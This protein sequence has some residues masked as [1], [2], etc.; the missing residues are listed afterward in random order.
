[1][2]RDQQ[3]HYVIYPD[4]SCLN[5][6]RSSGRESG[7][8]ATNKAGWGFVVTNNVP[9]V[10]FKN[11]EQLKEVDYGYGRI[12][13]EQEDH[14]YV[15]CEK[16][17]NNTA[18]ITAII[19]S[20]LWVYKH[21]EMTNFPIIIRP[22]S[23]YA[24]NQIQGRNATKKNIQLVINARKLLAAINSNRDH[25]VGPIVFKHVKA[26]SGEKWN[27]KADELAVR[28]AN[29][30]GLGS[31]NSSAVTTRNDKLIEGGSD[32]FRTIMARSVNGD[33]TNVQSSG[34]RFSP[35]QQYNS[36]L[37]FTPNSVGESEEN[38][39]VDEESDAQS[40]V[41][42]CNLLMLFMSISEHVF[43]A[44]VCDKSLKLREAEIIN[45]ILAN[46][47]RE[48]M[49]P[50]H[51]IELF[52]APKAF[53]C[54]PS[55]PGQNISSRKR[56]K[57]MI[58]FRIKCMEKWEKGGQHRDALVRTVLRTAQQKMDSHNNNNS[59]NTYSSTEEANIR[60]CERLA[61]EDSQLL[62]AV[63][64]LSS[65]GIAAAGP[66]TTAQL[67]EKHPQDVELPHRPVSNVTRETIEI[68][69]N[70]VLLA[71]KSFK[72][73]AAP[74]RSGMRAQHFSTFVAC[75]PD[76]LKNLTAVI[77]LLLKGLAPDEL[78]PFITGGSLIPLL[79]KDSSIRPIAI[80]ETLTRI[81]SKI[82]LMKTIHKFKDLTSKAQC[83]IGV[84]NGTEAILHMLNNYLYSEE[85]DE[86]SV[87][88]FVDFKNA[89]NTIR[90][91]PIVD[92]IDRDIPEISCWTQFCLCC[93]S[94]LFVPGGDT[95]RSCTGLQQG[96]PLSGPQWS[97]GAQPL[98]E[99]IATIISDT[100]P[101]RN[102]TAAA[103]MD[104]W[105]LL[106]PDSE[107]AAKILK[108][109]DIKGPPLG[110]YRSATK[111]VAWSLSK[112][113]DPAANDRL[114]QELSNSIV[115]S[116]KKGV[117]LLGGAMS[118]DAQ[119]CNE[120]ALK[121]V[122]IATELIHKVL[123]L[124]DP[125]ICLRLLRQCIGTVKLVYCIRT[126][127]TDAL[128][129]A[130][131]IFAEVLRDALRKIVV[132]NGPHLGDFHI[133]LASLPIK[134]SGLG[135]HMPADLASSAALASHLDTIN[136]QLHLCPSL[137]N[138]DI[139][140]NKTTKL[141]RSF[142]DNIDPS[143]MPNNTNTFFQQLSSL[144]NTQ[145]PLTRLQ[146]QSK[147]AI[148]LKHPFL[149]GQSDPLIKKLHRTILDSTGFQPT[150]EQANSTLPV[151]RKFDSIANHWLFAIPCAAFQ[152]TM[153][154]SEYRAALAL[155]ML[156][157]ILPASRQ[158][159][160]CKK[161]MMDK[162]G[163]HALSCGGISNK[164]TKRHETLNDAVFD[165]LRISQF[166]PIKNA[167]V[168]CLGKS[169]RDE[170]LFR[171]ADCL[172]DGDNGL[173]CLDTTVVSPL[174]LARCNMRL[175]DVVLDAALA[176]VNKHLRP[177]EAAHYGFIPFA[178]D[179]CGLIDWAA[180]TL[181]KRIGCKY[182]DNT[183]KSYSEGVSIVRQRLSFALQAGIA[184][185]LARVVLQR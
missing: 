166:N 128:T 4:G 30:N 157:P 122:T 3:Q 180:A 123:R 76:F 178:A 156:I 91:Q 79:K 150:R 100:N 160:S 158:C 93:A 41:W 162:Y 13:T 183:H 163:Y 90:R 145:H 132:N 86:G 176:K 75:H 177:C 143:V 67:L 55:E 170:H 69:Q 136:L 1:M 104:D 88:L 85:F 34:G 70:D 117:E 167:D 147:R 44:K 29:S 72:K 47:V 65:C 83:G 106:V 92:R 33:N 111:S 84:R 140:N 141:Q 43:T 31:A 35:S 168:Q 9:G 15:G 11:T 66:E 40:L 58:S 74:G 63:Q 129:E 125:H 172:F 6:Q 27:E 108:T 94:Y 173:T 171:P 39:S 56:R 57:N 134:M 59:C 169:S 14:E 119:F 45:K 126:L 127:P 81:V 98:L 179:T 42:D 174:S 137:A 109:I 89:F 144:S 110:L 155:R 175:G 149:T 68:N 48:P 23:D 103:I 139:I 46:I 185:Q 10:S 8:N 120:V 182:A 151:R 165:L 116:E 96:V 142:L 154:P 38:N 99:E 80:G 18:E 28:G 62:K 113:G 130:L 95:I 54:N 161:M 71:I 64:A 105:T 19:Q 97:L 5:N 7:N 101:D 184:R 133:L 37:S 159:T 16:A 102:T 135:I 22:D 36:Q 32:I 82:A 53:M 121:R 114:R 131:E 181:I 77:Q 87:A 148:L 49:Q 115:V 146:Y 153:H 78:A 24:I 25:T 26:H 73:G 2:A 124:E 138:G 60:R 20:L 61:R 164:R 12:I 118:T 107:T 17:T 51:H 152:Q 21:E 52:I 50:K 112:H